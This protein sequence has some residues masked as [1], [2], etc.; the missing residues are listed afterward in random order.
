[1]ILA[2]FFEKQN[3]KSKVKSSVDLPISI[4][5]ISDNLSHDPVAVYEY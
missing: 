4:A 3:W 2:K 1:M 5:I